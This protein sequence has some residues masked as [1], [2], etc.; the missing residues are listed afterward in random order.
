MEYKHVP[1]NLPSSTSIPL[2]KVNAAKERVAQKRAARKAQQEEREV[3]LQVVRKPPTISVF[4]QLWQKGKLVKEA[5]IFPTATGDFRSVKD[6]VDYA[7]QYWDIVNLPQ[8]NDPRY[9]ANMLATYQSMG[10]M[11]MGCVLEDGTT[12]NCYTV[13]DLEKAG[14]LS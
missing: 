8:I 10:V 6:F 14:F 3:Y 5:Y 2:E 13:D 11:S 12:K 7:K 1:I 9:Y 4:C